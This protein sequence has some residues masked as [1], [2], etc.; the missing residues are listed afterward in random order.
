MVPEPAPQQHATGTPPLKA[1]SSRQPDDVGQ[2]HWP[3]RLL[4]LLFGVT[5]LL[6]LSVVLVLPGIAPSP[7]VSDKQVPASTR[8]PAPATLDT[9]S[10]ARH[11]AEQA[12]R[13]YLRQRAL[14]ALEN[15]AQWAAQ[16]WQQSQQLAASADSLLGRG[17]YVEAASEY[18]Q[19]SALLGE[20]Q[21][22]KGRRFDR[23]LQDAGQLLERDAGQAQQLYEIALAMQPDS[24]SAAL[25]LERAQ[26]RPRID[27]LMR[28]AQL[29]GQQHQLAIALDMLTRALEL[30]PAYQPAQRLHDDLRQQHD[31]ARFEQFM[32]E[33][34][35]ALEQRR[36]VD[37]R[38]ALQAASQ[39]SPGNMAL[40]DVQARLDEATRQQSLSSIRQ[41]A[42]RQ[43][44]AE[45]WPAAADSYRQAL[46]I[47]PQTG[48]A[49]AGLARALDRQQLHRQLDHY[50]DDPQR[51]YSPEPL[52]NARQLLEE[53]ATGESGETGLQTKLDEL[54]LRVRQA[55]QPLPIT[56]TSDGQT[57]VAIYHVGR[58]GRFLS[59]QLE[60]RPGNY[61]AVGRRNGYRDV[62][63]EFSVLPGQSPVR[64]DVRC[65]EPV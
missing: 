40:Q 57:D 18:R 50:L 26:L 48:F 29:A 60:L 7:T 58:F 32:G 46:A 39:L 5:L 63:R 49:R 30:D 10:V 65:Q 64:L 22:D 14:P 16:E 47:D 9:P 6:V 37:A 31:A 2:R 59:R 43:E 56:M 12:L 21:Q 3:V 51:L 8:L 45:Q 17:Q 15:V 62:R 38:L 36:L 24:E 28:Q 61:V 34:L 20:L 13:D 4:W 33:A 25:G 55:A 54:R 44:A 1:P 52:A 27:E 35:A 19:A 42:L 23:L 41:R 53:L 11:D